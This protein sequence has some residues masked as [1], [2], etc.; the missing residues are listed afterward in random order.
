MLSLSFLTTKFTNHLLCAIVVSALPIKETQ[1]VS[2]S[3]SPENA[4]TG[5]CCLLY[6]HTTLESFSCLRESQT[7]L[8]CFQNKL[9]SVL[10]SEEKPSVLQ[11]NMRMW[12]TSS[13]Q[14]S[15]NRGAR[16][17]SLKPGI[18]LIQSLKS[19]LEN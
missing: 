9:M 11:D 3:R 14:Q 18:R 12:I 17:T 2:Q 13:Y 16:P 1:A 10:K 7:K 5:L 19:R 15:V 6:E 4:V 8:F